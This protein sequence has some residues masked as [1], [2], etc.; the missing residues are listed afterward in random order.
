[1]TVETVYEVPLIL[2]QAGLGDLITEALGLTPQEPGLDEWTELVQRV[3]AP[4]EPLPVAVVGKYAD[5]PDAYISVKEAL[6]HAALSYGRDVQI[7]WIPSEELERN[8]VD[9]LLHWAC[10]IVVPGGFGPRGVNGMLL[11]ARY[12]REHQVPYLGLCLGLQLM[13]VEA[14]RSCGGLS[15]A[16]ST[17]FDPETPYPVI[18]LM[19]EQRNIK[20]LGGTMRL[21]VYPCDLVPGSKAHLAYDAPR[22]HER[23]RHRFELNNE[24]R[25]ALEAAGLRFSGF[26][27]DRRLV[28]IAERADHPFMLGTQFHPEFLS[29]PTRPHPL[30]RAFIGAANKV[31][32]EGGQPPLPLETS[33]NGA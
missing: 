8:G 12:A 25:G 11:A 24:Y 4:K 6:R 21:G 10:G 19:P 30:F 3:K 32:R 14:A 13:V 17:E 29:R 5:L 7:T 9:S 27:P 2:H 31:V 23:H 1:M 28:E 22:V 26:S 16:H 20:D 33:G 18:D 15:T